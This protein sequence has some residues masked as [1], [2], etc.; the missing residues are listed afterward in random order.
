MEYAS[1]GY[2][3]LLWESEITVTLPNRF[4]SGISGLSPGHFEFAENLEVTEVWLRLLEALWDHWKHLE[5]IV[6]CCSF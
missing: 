3:N 6:L 5:A 2:A 1:V 4:Y